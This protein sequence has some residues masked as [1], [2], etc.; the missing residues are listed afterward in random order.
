MVNNC[1][2]IKCG[3]CG[4]IKLK[5]AFVGK[6]LNE[7]CS[8]KCLAAQ[9]DACECKCGRKFHAGQNLRLLNEILKPK[10]KKAAVKK[11]DVK[12]VT[13]KKTVKKRKPKTPFFEPQTI[14]D[15]VALFIQGKRFLT[16]SF[17]RFSDK[18]YRRDQK[19]LALNWLSKKGQSLDVAA[20][21]FINLTD[22]RISE[23]EVIDLIVEIILQYPSGIKAYIKDALY[24]KDLKEEE[25]AELIKQNFYSNTDYN[26]FDLQERV[27]LENEEYNKNYIEPVLIFGTNKMKL[28]KGSAAAKAFMAKIRAKKGNT[29]K[30]SGTKNLVTIK[31]IPKDANIS[32]YKRDRLL[33]NKLLRD[34]NKYGELYQDASLS[35]KKIY[36][37]KLD[38]I[39]TAL[40]NYERKNK[41]SGWKKGNTK[42]I[43]KEEKPFKTL[44]TVKVKRRITTAPKGTFKKFT[45]INGTNKNMKKY[46]YEQLENI[47]LTR[48][49]NDVNGNPRYV[50][51]FLEILNK[52]EE[53]FLP[54]SKKYDYALKKAKIIGGRKFHNKQYGGGIV[55]QSYNTDNLKENIIDVMETTPKI[56]Y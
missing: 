54:F 28:K 33:Y 2:H 11:I 41:V 22:Y 7:V 49:N 35:N 56:K 13:A 31:K 4:G 5:K 32:T 10:K 29:K 3:A 52:E 21:D 34:Y 39:E 8:G 30:V 43:E 9:K 14:K 37:I 44:K 27:R 12:K 46:D 23:S 6:T 48:V 53:A 16:K 24:F 51:H 38:K 15:E 19:T 17:D 26:D 47:K 55:F 42:F 50:L 40:S 20:L 36:K 25:E 1:K 45:T 18:N